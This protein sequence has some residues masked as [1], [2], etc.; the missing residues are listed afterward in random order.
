M[1]LF[2]IPEWVVL[3]PLSLYAASYLKITR[4]STWLLPIAVAFLCFDQLAFV[5]NVSS[6]DALKIAAIMTLFITILLGKI[7]KLNSW[8]LAFIFWIIARD[9]IAMITNNIDFEQARWT[10]QFFV[11]NLSIIATVSVITSRFNSQEMAKIVIRAIFVLLSVSLAISIYQYLAYP[12]GL[13]INGIGSAFSKKLGLGPKFASYSYDGTSYFRPYALFGEPKFLAAASVSSL[14]FVIFCFNQKIAN[15]KTLIL[16]IVGVLIILYLTAST[17]GMI[18]LLILMIVVLSISKISLRIKLAIGVNLFFVILIFWIFFDLESFIEQRFLNRIVNVDTP[19]ENHEENYLNDW[20][21]SLQTFVF[22]L[23]YS[24]F[25][26]ASNDGFRL[27]P[28]GV[29]IFYGVSGGVIL[30][31]I[32]LMMFIRDI[33][34]WK[35]MIIFT[36]CAAIYST[37]SNLFLLLIFSTIALKI[38]AK[39][40]KNL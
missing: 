21:E 38:I 24:H 2:L 15:K 29:S 26:V 36:P 7:P 11:I 12:I 4:Q 10:L 18:S 5:I 23:G 28:N 25:S 33:R 22:G 32:Y 34:Y 1:N 30:V 16:S 27:I 6:I 39:P 8:E 14:S 13:P 37:N 40:T 35:Q 31:G 19:L 20:F 3:I 9:L 17:S